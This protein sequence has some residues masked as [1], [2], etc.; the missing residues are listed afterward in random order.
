MLQ[1][2][3]ALLRRHAPGDLR[4]RRQQREAAVGRGDGFV[5]DAHRLRVAH[6]VGQRLAGGEVEVGEE[7]LPGAQQ[8]ILLRLRLLDVQQQVAAF[9][10]F[11]R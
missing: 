4:H 7:H 3:G 1:V 11:G 6:G 8:R 2:L 10:N 9:I 5:G